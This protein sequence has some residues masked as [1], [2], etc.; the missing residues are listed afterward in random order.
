MIVGVVAQRT[1]LCFVSGIR[2]AVLFKDFRM[3]LYFLAILATVLIGNIASGKFK[4]SFAEQPI[5]HT[6]W[7][8]NILGLYAVG[9]GSVLL[10]GC[11]LR[12]LV[13]AG[14]GNSDSGVT[15]LGYLVGAAICHNFGLAS[16]AAGTT[17]AGRVAFFIC[18]AVMFAIAILN[19]S[20]SASA[21]G[22]TA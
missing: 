11:P 8:W 19:T 13:L 6:E 15:V 20:K 4:L 21:Q 3:L 17:P 10:G 16:S 22:V 1:R 18:A 2:D 5:A 14:S 12:Q 7:I 9:F